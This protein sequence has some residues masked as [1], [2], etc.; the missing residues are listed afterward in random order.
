MT[1]VSVGIPS[2]NEE[3]NIKRIL[4]KVILS[5]LNS[6]D[7]VEIIISDDSTDDTPNIV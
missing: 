6:I 5:N 2:Y 7:L 3:S 4:E 1:T